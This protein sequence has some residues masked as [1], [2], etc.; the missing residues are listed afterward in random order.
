MENITQVIAAHEWRGRR[1]AVQQKLVN[2]ELF[3][4]NNWLQ[5]AEDDK[6]VCS[7]SLQPETLEE[8]EQLGYDITRISKEENRVVYKFA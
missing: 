7:A 8:L 4:I 5:S 1:A 3:R 6:C 2:D